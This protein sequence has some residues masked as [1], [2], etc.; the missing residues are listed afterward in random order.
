MTKKT[1]SVNFRKKLFDYNSPSLSHREREVLRR[2]LSFSQRG[3]AYHRKGGV[4]REK[5]SLSQRGCTYIT[6]REGFSGR[7]REGGPIIENEGFSE[8]G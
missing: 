3:R 1:D 4:L 2:R 8:R 7:G 6:D 5:P